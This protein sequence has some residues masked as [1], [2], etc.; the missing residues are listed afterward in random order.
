MGFTLDGDR[1]E[2]SIHICEAGA[3][4]ILKS[5]AFHLRGRDKDAYDAD[6]ILRAYPGGIDA[7]AERVRHLPNTQDKRRG[8][9]WMQRAYAGIDSTGPRAVARF[10]NRLTDDEFKVDVSNRARALLTAAG[11]PRPTDEPPARGSHATIP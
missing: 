1:A 5:L 6:W 2:R 10:L 4:T 3:F 8:L 7:V 11:P 9:D